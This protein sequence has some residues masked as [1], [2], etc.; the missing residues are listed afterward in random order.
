MVRASAVGSAI[1]WYDFFL[2]GTAAAIVFPHV[3]FPSF[4]PLAGTLASFGAFAA[5]FIA[6]PIG[7]LV[8]GH[9]GDRIGRKSMLVMTILVMGTASFLMGLLPTYGQIGVWAPVL[10]V[11]LR[12]AQGFGV[13][14]E[15]AGAQLM[16]VEYAPD[17][18]R[19]IMGCWPIG[20]AMFGLAGASAMLALGEALLTQDQFMSWGWRVPFLISIFLVAV[21]MLIRVRV[22]ETPVFRD[23]LDRRDQEKIPFLQ[24]V[25][26]FPGQALRAVGMYLGI[27]VVYYVVTVFLV[28]YATKELQ[29]QH[30]VVLVVVVLAQVVNLGTCLLGA[31]LS[32]RIGRRPVFIGFASAVIVVAFPSFALIDHAEPWS[33]FLGAAL[34]GG[35]LFG[36]GGVQGAFFAESFP[37]RLRY[38]AVAMSTTV[39]TLIGG[40]LTPALGTLLVTW[41]GGSSEGVALYVIVLAAIGGGCAFFSKETYKLP[42]HET[43]PTAFSSKSPTE[44]SLNDV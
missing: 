3:F 21:G 14:G 43:T 8:A 24:L 23:V 37:P 25:R 15:M 22:L 29:M 30:A 7:G 13:G 41:S 6:R 42:L 33:L 40:A 35:C 20:T 31:A 18:R 10:L 1:E 28:S 38:T 4:D 16:C 39:A 44:R 19:G 2:F 34:L 36:Y 26:E 27:T 12:I 32:D 11:I 17:N 5:G 9:L